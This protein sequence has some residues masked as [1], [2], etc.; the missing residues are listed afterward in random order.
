[1]SE[2]NAHMT[3]RAAAAKL[4]DEVKRATTRFAD[5]EAALT[6]RYRQ[7]TPYRFRG[8]WGPAHFNNFAYNRDGRHLDPMRPEAL[9]YIK[10]EDGRI[11]L[12]GAMFVAPK[13]QGPRPAGPLTE[14]HVHDNLCLTGSGSVALATGPGQCPPGSF[15]VGEAVEMMHVWF[16]DHPDGPF[17][18]D[19][20]AAA[21]REAVHYARGR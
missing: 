14:W 8:R 2:L 16:F 6:D 12:L 4:L 17:A 20:T 19:L 7:T 3:R 13:G 10:L 5:V 15:F 11:V 9:V 21:I 1:M 18:H